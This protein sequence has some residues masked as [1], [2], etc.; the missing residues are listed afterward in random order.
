MNNKII[1]VIIIGVLLLAGVF[2]L[3]KNQSQ[4]M[5]G[6]DSQVQTPQEVTDND[7]AMEQEDEAVEDEDTSAMEEVES[8]MMETVTVS[9]NDTGYEPQTLNIKSGGKVEWLNNTRQTGNVSSA[10]HPTHEEYPPL[11]LGNFEPGEKVSLIFSEPGTY[12]YHDHLNP[13]TFGTVV[14]E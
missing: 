1:W 2:V 6:T 13:S 14:V 11:N 5:V 7:D 9:L 8:S 12:R 3:S 10:V 4:T